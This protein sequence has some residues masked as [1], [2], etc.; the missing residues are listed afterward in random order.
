MIKPIPA[1][2]CVIVVMSAL[3]SLA[4]QDATP[5]PGKHGAFK[6]SVDFDLMASWAYKETLGLAKPEAKLSYAPMLSYSF[7]LDETNTLGIVLLK[8]NHFAL[9]QDPVCTFG[10]GFQFKHYWNPA[11]ADLGAYLPWIS[12]GILLSQAVVAN[13][14]G[15]AIGHNTRM[16]LGT[17]IVLAPAHH[18]V[19]Q[20]AWDSVDFPT[21]GSTASNSLGMMSAGLG[22][23]FLF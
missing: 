13:T 14:P 5:P 9:A 16:G 3:S 15:R 20:A 22:Y 1:L 12:Y 2:V 10:Y 8:F 17:D 18:L 23:R 6:R 21:L 7:L 4:A 11:W 19:L